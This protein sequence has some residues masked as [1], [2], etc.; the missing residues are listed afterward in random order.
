MKEATLE[1]WNWV[2]L[3]GTQA[4]LGLVSPNFRSVVLHLDESSWKFE[5]T[6]RNEDKQDRLAADE[7]A[8]QFFL[9]LSDIRDAIGDGLYLDTTEQVIVSNEDIVLPPQDTCRVLFLM[10]EHPIDEDTD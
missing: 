6:I 4:L 3:M 2:T 1:Q 7:I 5:I 9:Y 8:E 10:R